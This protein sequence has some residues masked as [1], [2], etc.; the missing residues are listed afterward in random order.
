MRA[1][2]K[3]IVGATLNGQR[4][5][6]GPLPALQAIAA[7][8]FFKNRGYVQLTMTDAETGHDYTSGK[9]TAPATETRH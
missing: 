2:Q 1:G 8:N 4:Q 5:V 6:I 7:F 9:F 3:M